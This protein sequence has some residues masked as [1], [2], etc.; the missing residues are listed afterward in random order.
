MSRAR[1]VSKI[2]I[3]LEGVNFSQLVSTLENVVT[4]EQLSTALENVTVDLSGYATTEQ[5][6]ASVSNIDL[7]GY[8]TISSASSTYATNESL[9]AIDVD[10]LPDDLM[11]MGG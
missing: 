11:T 7:S 1:E 9:S 10:N 3:S 4:D 6:S 2:A 5:L 8:L